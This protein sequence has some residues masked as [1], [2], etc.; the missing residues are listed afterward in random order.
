MIVCDV[1]SAEE[2]GGI[3][4]GG[5]R[6]VFADSK[7]AASMTVTYSSAADVWLMRFGVF[8]Y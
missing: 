2:Q 1:A 7:D 4:L 5:K 3:A 8:P 6:L